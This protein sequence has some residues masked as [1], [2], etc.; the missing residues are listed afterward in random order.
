MSCLV[1]YKVVYK[2]K[3]NYGLVEKK[4]CLFFAI[5]ILTFSVHDNMNVCTQSQIAKIPSTSHV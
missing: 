2:K 4:L 1:L 5:S 3:K